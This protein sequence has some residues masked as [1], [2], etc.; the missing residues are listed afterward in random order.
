[1]T[2]DPDR[3][4]LVRRVGS[5]SAWTTPEMTAYVNEDHLQRIIAEDPDRVL[6]VPEGAIAVRELPTSAGPADVCI[7]S[8]D[9]A[10]TVVECKLASNSERR[11]MVIGQVLDYAAAIWRDGEAAFHEQWARRGGDDLHALGEGGFE[12]LGRNIAAGRIH[13]CLAVDQIDADLRRLVEY[14]N[15]ITR[16]DITVTA[17]QLSYARHGDLEILIPSTYGGE[18]A[19]AKARAAAGT[20]TRW[21]KD[22]FLDSIGSD[23]D[24]ASAE[25]LFALLDEVDDRRGTHDDLWYGNKPGGGV[26]FHPYELRYAP[27]Q[28]WINKSGQLMAYG[29]WYQYDE[30]KYHRGFA[31]LAHLVGQDHQSTAEG[32]PIAGLTDLDRIWSITVRCA[33]HINRPDAEPDHRD[34]DPDTGVI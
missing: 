18:I 1:M 11:R 3:G 23:A 5:T 30:I 6:G 22:T 24:R 14:L 33:E 32:F 26:F 17:L 25:K 31:E 12:Q 27:I 7:V 21:T 9:G 15:Q 2:H 8:P 4:V 29:I 13:L 16:D 20:T 34:V 10:L 19:A 28:L